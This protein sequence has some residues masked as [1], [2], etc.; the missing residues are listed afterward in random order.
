ML[1][2]L[3]EWLVFYVSLWMFGVIGSGLF[4]YSLSSHP[5]S[6]TD[7]VACIVLGSIAGACAFGVVA[8]K[9]IWI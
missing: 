2:F 7:R 9:F 3:L 5:L 6:W 4:Y 8:F 1:A